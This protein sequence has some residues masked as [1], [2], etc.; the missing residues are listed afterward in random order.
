MEVQ[1]RINK[2]MSPKF[3]GTF[4]YEKQLISWTVLITTLSNYLLSGHRYQVVSLCV[5][6]PMELVNME[7]K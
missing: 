1:N 6:I 5:L 4:F 7:I 2:K 3:M